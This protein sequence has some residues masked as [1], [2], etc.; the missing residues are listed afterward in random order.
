[1]GWYVNPK[2]GKKEDWLEQHGTRHVDP[3][4]FDR[5]VQMGRLPVVL[6]DNGPFT[7]AGIAYCADE[8]SEFTR[9]GDIRHKIV[10]TVPIMDLLAL[11]KD[12]EDTSLVAYIETHYEKAA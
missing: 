12:T 9:P 1:M 10:Y 11:A 7:A 8:L 2:E 3:V 5:A 6:L 4:D